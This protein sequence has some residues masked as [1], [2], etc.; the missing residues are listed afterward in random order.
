[1][2]WPEMEGGLTSGAPSA[3]VMRRKPATLAYVLGPM[4]GTCMVKR[5]EVDRIRGD[6]PLL[7]SEESSPKPSCAV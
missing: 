4:P 1:M 2:E 7:L 3:R 6:G 5:G